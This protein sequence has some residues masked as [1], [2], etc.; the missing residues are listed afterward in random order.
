VIFVERVLAESAAAKSLHLVIFNNDK[1]A[2]LTGFH[3]IDWANRKAAIG[4]LLGADQQGKGLMT[5]SCRELLSLAFGKLKLNRV[6]LLAAP[7]NK[8]SQA[9]AKRLK[10][11]HE[12]TVREAEWLYDHFVDLDVY[13]KLAREWKKTACCKSTSSGKDLPTLRQS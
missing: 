7:R 11:K 6:E 9:V 3:L 2:G 12:G 10:M 8:R 13:S 4:Y 1:L 5:I